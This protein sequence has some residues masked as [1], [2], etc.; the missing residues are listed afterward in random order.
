MGARPIAHRGKEEPKLL[1]LLGCMVWEVRS[2]PTSRKMVPSGILPR[3]SRVKPL[4]S[5][6]N[7]QG[8][9]PRGGGSKDCIAVSVRDSVQG[10][11]PSWVEQGPH[12][13]SHGS[14]PRDLIF[15]LPNPVS[16]LPKPREAPVSR[17]LGGSQGVGGSLEPPSVL[18]VENKS[19]S[20][21]QRGSVRRLSVSLRPSPVPREGT[22][23][24]GP[25]AVMLP[26]SAFSGPSPAVF[27]P[28][29][30][31]RMFSL[32]QETGVLIPFVSSG[33]L[34]HFPRKYPPSTSFFPPHG[35]LIAAESG[36]APLV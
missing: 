1:Q 21:L 27:L 2:A 33:I 14:S 3:G 7:D 18:G 32:A 26:Q 19:T 28:A 17:M 25:Q 5:A 20:L 36:H 4:R 30:Q 34:E 24:P 29:E 22:V 31:G 15:V 11:R 10:V 6:W 35:I 13:Q 12:V 16:D 23:S 8:R 9:L